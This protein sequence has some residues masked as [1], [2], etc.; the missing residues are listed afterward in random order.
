MDFFRFLKILDILV[1][2][3]LAAFFFLAGAFFLAAFFFLAGAFFF[4]VANALTP[5][6]MISIS[7][8]FN[9]IFSMFFLLAEKLS[10]DCFHEFI[11]RE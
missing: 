7:Y 11:F 2:L 6:Q 9:K 1:F 4:F 3:F 8:S 10:L 5:F